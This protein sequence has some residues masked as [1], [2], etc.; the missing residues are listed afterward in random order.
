[1]EILLYHLHAP[2]L[3][4][5]ACHFNRRRRSPLHQ[6]QCGLF[7]FDGQNVWKEH[8][9]DDGGRLLRD[10]LALGYQLHRHV[11]LLLLRSL[12]VVQTGQVKTVDHRQTPQ[13]KRI[14]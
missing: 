13:L 10:V 1:M 5:P 4:L 8:D 6:V 11:H 12:P 3:C 7:A 9:L 2:H 14:M